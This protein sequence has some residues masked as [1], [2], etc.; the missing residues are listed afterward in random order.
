M[1][2]IRPESFKKSSLLK[3]GL[4]L[5]CLLVLANCTRSRSGT[6]SEYG[7]DN[8]ARNSNSEQQS[9]AQSQKENSL[10]LSITQKIRQ[11]IVDDNSLS[12][13]ARNVKIIT[14]DGQVTL[15]GPVDTGVEKENIENKA[16]SVAG[17][18]HVDNQLEVK[19]Q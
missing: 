10:D 8:S 3:N 7:A 19:K 13:N 1:K 12:M 4:T 2:M 17:V 14:R 16:T 5:I 15:R 11:A 9:T 18:S 6:A